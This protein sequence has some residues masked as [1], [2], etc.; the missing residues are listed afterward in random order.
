M[1]TSIV[2]V[3]PGGCMYCT[4]SS[5]T[6]FAVRLRNPRRALRLSRGQNE[7]VDMGGSEEILEVDGRWRMLYGI[8]NVGLC[9]RDMAVA[10]P[11]S[12]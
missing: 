8:G 2:E 1:V 7:W 4:Y 6:L 12:S 3:V 5:H 10:A 9:I 11:S